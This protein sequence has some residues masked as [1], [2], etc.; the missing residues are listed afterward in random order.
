MEEGNFGNHVSI[1]P[2]VRPPMN[3][4]RHFRIQAPVRFGGKSHGH[5]DVREK[6]QQQCREFI[7]IKFNLYTDIDDR[8]RARARD[9]KER[10]RISL[11]EQ[12]SN[13][14]AAVRK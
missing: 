3:E 13:F 14:I 6:K 2:S 10:R 4:S 11:E 8:E 5:S 7:L 9:K 1:R 12:H